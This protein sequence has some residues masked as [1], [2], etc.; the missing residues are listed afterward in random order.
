[1]STTKTKPLVGPDPGTEDWF[2]LRQYDPQRKDRPVLFGASEAAALLGVSKYQS[3]ADLYWRKLGGDEPVDT[4][5]MRMGRKLEPIILEEYVTQT[6]RS[7]IAPTPCY[8]HSDVPWLMATPDAI[9]GDSWGVEAKA[10]SFRMRDNTGDDQHRF[11]MGDD[12]IPLD[13][14]C[15]AQHQMTVM[16][17]DWV[18]FAV[19]FDGRDFATYRVKRDDDIVQAIIDAGEVMAQRVIQK[20]PP[21]IDED[22]PRLGQFLAR[23]R[24]V[25][26]QVARSATDAECDLWK[27]IQRLGAEQTVL[28]RK[29][30]TLRNRLL[31]DMG[32]ATQLVLPDGKVRR[33]QVD[34]TQWTE[35][36]VAQALAKVGTCKRA[37]YQFLRKAK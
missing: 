2:A 33:F 11:G 17:W 26:S 12:E 8:F 16:G 15:Q 13:Y 23:L 36:D 28:K 29:E 4:D 32:D 20:D 10:S 22:D 14:I 34:E 27:Q 35:D 1:M 5:A 18:D 37:A 31:M 9:G 6:G 24:P 19:L 7:I 25:A 21:R 3:P 30:R